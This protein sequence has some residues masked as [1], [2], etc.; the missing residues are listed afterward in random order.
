MRDWEGDMGAAR[1]MAGDLPDANKDYSGATHHEL[2]SSLVAVHAL[3]GRAARLRDK[4][5]AELAA[6][7]KQREEIRADVRARSQPPSR[8]T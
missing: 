5:L 8:G 6:N 4:Y 2:E 7:D 1:S 3:A